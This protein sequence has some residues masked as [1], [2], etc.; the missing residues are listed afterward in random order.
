MVEQCLHLRFEVKALV[1]EEGAFRSRTRLC[2]AQVCRAALKLPAIQFGI[3]AQPNVIRLQDIITAVYERKRTDFRRPQ[4][5]HLVLMLVNTVEE[6]HTRS[7]SL[8]TGQVALICISNGDH[9]CKAVAPVSHRGQ[10]MDHLLR[11]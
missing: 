2:P 1:V 5:V 4:M 3:S 6:L 8:A 11:N 10:S 9:G 7:N